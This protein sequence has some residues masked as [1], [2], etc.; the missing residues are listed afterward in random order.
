MTGR[1]L[2]FTSGKRVVTRLITSWVRVVYGS[3]PSTRKFIDFP[4]PPFHINRTGT[5][6]LQPSP[7]LVVLRPECPLS[8]ES[9][10]VPLGTDRK[11]WD[12]KRGCRDDSGKESNVE[13]PNDCQS[14]PFV[15]SPYLGHPGNPEGTWGVTWGSRWGV[16]RW[17]GSEN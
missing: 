7:Y 6:S 16:T 1:G 5:S 12:R 8:R 3:L 11:G 17:V 13:G 9:S 15:S 10:P 14:L 4:T 2:I